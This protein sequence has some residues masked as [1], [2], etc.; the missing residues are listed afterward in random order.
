MSKITRGINRIDFKEIAESCLSK[1]E[2]HIKLGIPTNGTSTRAVN[3]KL[4]ELGITIKY[5]S[6]KYVRATR[7][8][9]ICG[10]PFITVINHPREKQTCS[11]ACSNTLFRS[12]SNNGRHIQAIS[13]GSIKNYRARCF[14]AHEKRC[15]ICG[16][17]R[18]VEVHHLDE[19]TTNVNTNNLIPLCPTHHQLFHTSK[20]HSEIK[21]LIDRWR[22]GRDSN[23]QSA[24]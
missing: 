16:E 6:T 4:Q 10:E 5:D 17:H 7:S 8:C 19:V 9:P 21:E 1:S 11:Y 18:I 23:P 2:L 14:S 22:V 12:G 13:D 20:Y 24:E 3:S 15:C